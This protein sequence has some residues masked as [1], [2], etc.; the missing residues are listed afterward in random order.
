VFTYVQPL[1]P[2]VYGAKQGCD[3]KKLGAV[4]VYPYLNVLVIVLCG[5]PQAGAEP[6]MVVQMLKLFIGWADGFGYDVLPPMCHWID[7]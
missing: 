4:G 3:I 7:D 6:S 1:H 2:E 5:I